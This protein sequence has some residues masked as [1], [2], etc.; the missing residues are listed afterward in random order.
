MSYANVRKKL[1]W[2]SALV[3]FLAVCFL[4]FATF[5]PSLYSISTWIISDASLLTVKAFIGFALVLTWLIVLRIA[6]QGLQWL[7]LAYIGM[8]AVI[9]MLLE[10]QF[11]MFRYLP[12]YSQVLMAEL[13][14]ALAITFGLVF[15]YWV[16][17]FAGQS[18]VVKH[19]P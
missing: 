9:G 19:P 3:R 14:I 15:S 17:Q 13:G 10:W 11:P 1:P 6:I 8:A 2:K 16:R 18:A 12:L 7:G 5:N 4:V